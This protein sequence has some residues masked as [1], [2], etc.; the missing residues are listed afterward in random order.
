[1]KKA[2]LIVFSVLLIMVLF[3][4]ISKPSTAVSATLD[5]VA[6]VVEVNTG[7]GWQLA[8]EGMPLTETDAIRTQ[9]GE[10][11]IIIFDSI[12][13]QLG[14]FTDL[15]MQ[16]LVQQ[17]TVIKQHAGSTWN[18]FL[19]DEGDAY[20]IETPTTVATVRS[21][22]FG[23]DIDD[24][25]ESVMVAE[26]EVEFMSG[27]EQLLV[28]AFE[29]GVKPKAKEMVMKKLEGE[30][31]EVVLHKMKKTAKTLRKMGT[32]MILEDKQF[33]QQYG[34]KMETVMERIEKGEITEEQ[35]MGAMETRPE[36]AKKITRVM[37]EIKDQEERIVTEERMRDE[38]PEIIIEEI[39]EERVEEKGQ[40]I[41]REKVEE[42]RDSIAEKRTEERK[43]EPVKDEPVDDKPV[44]DKPDD[45]FGDN[46]TTTDNADDGTTA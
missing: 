4:I 37:K 26:G 11:I 16:S 17:N 13:V 31:R 21:T 14:T 39:I 25:E 28:K 42:K 30:K 3:L 36:L 19:G 40:E 20:S 45:V 32:K 15:S 12:I 6:G 29:H 18:K 23:V 2:F 38:K 35:V 27:K 10:A 24:E 9:E 5:S 8:E 34:D 43:E 33:R 7:N 1:M 44:D 46:E 41:I 22:E